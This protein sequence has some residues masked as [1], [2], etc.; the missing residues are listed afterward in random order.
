VA[1]AG[2]AL[3]ACTSSPAATRE[4]S[5]PPAAAHRDPPP[6]PKTDCIDLGSW[7]D[8][9]LAAETTVVP[10][11]ES[12]LAAAQPEVAAGSGGV[13]LFGSEAPSEL[14]EQVATLERAVPDRHG[15]LVMTDEEG[16]EVQR[17]ANLVGNLPWASYMGSEWTPGEITSTVAKVARAMTKAGVDMDLA[18]VVDVDGRAVLPGAADPDGYRSFGGHTGVA[19]GDGVAFMRGLEQGGVIPVLK[20]FPGLGGASA[21]TDDARA[22][23]LPWGQLRSTGVPPFAAAIAAGAPAVMISNAI[24]PGLTSLPAS[25]SPVVIE[26]ELEGQLG[27]RGLVITDSLSA[28]A[29]SAAGFTVASAASRAL[30]SGADMVIYNAS[31]TASATYAQFKKIVDTEVAAVQGGRLARSR[32]VSAARAALAVRHLDVCA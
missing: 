18:P 28:V 22:T 20:H 10:A 6:A 31:K 8:A 2:L 30:Q 15:L 11:S 25:L 1:A 7:S 19:S 27:F 21:N 3:A 13:I 16:G 5:S 24:V 14:G 9:R 12:D 4:R 17:M 23:T 32:L 26:D 29:I